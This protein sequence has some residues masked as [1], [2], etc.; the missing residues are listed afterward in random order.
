MVGG[1]RLDCADED[2][3]GVGVDGEGGDGGV[4]Q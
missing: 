1:C 3:D 4:R 2:E